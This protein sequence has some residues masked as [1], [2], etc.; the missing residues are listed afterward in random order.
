MKMGHNRN[1]LFATVTFEDELLKVKIKSN[2]NNSILSLKDDLLKI[3]KNG[4]SNTFSVI[5]KM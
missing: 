5:R 4:T 1:N 2:M 3:A